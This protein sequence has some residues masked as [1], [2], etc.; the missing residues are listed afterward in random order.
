M[1]SVWPARPTQTRPS[2]C[3]YAL[4]RQ[5]SLSCC[6]LLIRLS[7]CSHF[8]PPR[9]A[10]GSASFFTAYDD[11]SDADITGNDESD[12]GSSSG[13]DTSASSTATALPTSKAV[14]QYS[15][16]S[17]VLDRYRV[18]RP[19]EIFCGA[20]TAIKVEVSRNPASSL[21]L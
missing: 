16:F 14:L 4:N 12:P 8:P 13:S 1:P 3:K 15:T 19:T 2:H 18:L 21:V 17:S 6:Q 10:S 5:I 20:G 7:L 11:N 9:R